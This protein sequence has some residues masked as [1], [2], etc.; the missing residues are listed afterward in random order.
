[1]AQHQVVLSWTG[2]VDM[3]TPIP[4]GDGYNIFRGINPAAEGATPI[5]GSTPVAANTY[6]DLSV[7]AGVTY[8]YYVTAVLN[9][10]QSADSNQVTAA[11][12]LFPPTGLVAAAS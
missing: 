7:S 2:S 10:I 1:M 11:V 9:G 4:A 5:N 3:P 12:P 6:T 8:D